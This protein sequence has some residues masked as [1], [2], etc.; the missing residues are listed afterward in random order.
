[1][2]LIFYTLSLL[3]TIL[4]VVFPQTKQTS[5]PK[6]LL[7]HRRTIGILAFIVAFGH[8]YI[9]VK[10][11]DIDF[12]D[13]KTFWVYIQGVVTFIIFT[14]LAITSNDWSV[15]RLKKNWKRL[16]EL[17]YLAMFMLT[18]HVFDKMAGQ[19]TYLTPFGAIMITGI[20]LL[21]LV[22]RWKE[23]QVQQQKKAKSATAD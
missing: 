23:W 20:T 19:W 22:R 15:K 10:K 11:R 18:W 2:A 9:L 1:M 8:G 5:I 4:R 14:L 13:L 7:K 3:P 6:F 21:F 12:S 17:T 16:H